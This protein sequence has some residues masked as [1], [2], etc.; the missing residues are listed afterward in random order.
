[1]TKDD[2][3]I[4]SLE[5]DRWQDKQV[6]RRNAILMIVQKGPPALRRWQPAAAHIPSNRR[7]SDLETE[8]EKL[9]MNAWCAPEMVRAAH[10][11]ND[12]AQLS[13]DLRSAYMVARSPAPI[14]SKPSAV[15]TNDRFRP[16]NRNRAKDGGEPVIKP[17]KQKAIGIVEVGRFGARRRSTLICCRST[18]ISASSFALDLKSEAKTPKISLSSSVIRARAYPV[19]S[20]R[21]R[22]IKFSVHTP[23]RV[24]ARGSRKEPASPA[25]AGLGVRRRRRVSAGKLAS[26]QATFRSQP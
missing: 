14:C 13:Q 6:D 1:M 20:L 4:K 17:N 22:R 8:L 18:R 16:D 11:A 3:A 2:K 10:L 9:T 12:R 26:Q 24:A 7:L 19:R 23:E 5:R 25:A 15:P 21:I